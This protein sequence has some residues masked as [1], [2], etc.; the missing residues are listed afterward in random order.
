MFQSVEAIAAILQI[1]KPSRGTNFSDLAIQALSG[2]LRDSRIIQEILTVVKTLSSDALHGLF[3][4]LPR[5]LAGSN[6]FRELRREYQLLLNKKLGDDP[7][8]TKYDHHHKTHKTTLVEQR[9]KLAT[10][11]AKLSKQDIEY[12]VFVDRLHAMLG[13][14]FSDALVNPQELFMHEAFI[15]DL[16]MPIKDVF[17]PK[18]RF[19]TERALSSPFDYLVSV[20]ATAEDSLSA[21]QPATSILYRLYLESGSLINTYDLWRAFHIIIIGGEDGHNC[22]ER[23]ALALFYR[24]LSELK[25]MGMVKQSRKKID[26]IAK[27][28]WM[29]L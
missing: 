20:S 17:T 8:R 29:G 1:F 11:N 25:M 3:E 23:L 19:S 10:G 14:Y 24:A 18:P 21:S 5:G 27:S 12:T 6:D 7:L 16:R 4:A 2:E 13:A 22:G 15:Y 9:V 26:H 28:A